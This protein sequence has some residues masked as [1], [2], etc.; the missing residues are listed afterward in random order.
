MAALSIHDAVAA[1][2]REWLGTPYHHQQSAKGVGCDCL[3]LLR[4]VWRAVIGPEPARA[5]NYSRDWAEASGRETLIEACA[6]WLEPYP[7]PRG[8]TGMAGD[9]LV[10]RMAPGRRAKHCAI[11][12]APGRMVHSLEGHGVRED[13][14]AEFLRTRRTARIAGAF[15]FPG[16]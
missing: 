13:G 7:L 10:F 3:G 14:I 16:A 1:E 11:V 12:V 6:Q 5:P 4:G 15:S 2:A 9:V 8:E